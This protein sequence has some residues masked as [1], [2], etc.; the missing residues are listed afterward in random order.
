MK[1]ILI[2]ALTALM[3]FSLSA[4]GRSN[5][6]TMPEETA[7]QSENATND[8]PT[9]DKNVPDPH[10]NNNS[11]DENDTTNNAPD[12]EGV[13]DDTMDKILGEN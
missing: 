5:E 13:L 10:V 2:F 4:C 1:K 6:S 8:M 7:P 11:T 3:L 9:V 12:R